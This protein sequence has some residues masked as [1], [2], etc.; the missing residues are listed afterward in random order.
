MSLSDSRP[1]ALQSHGLSGKGINFGSHTYFSDHTKDMK[2]L[3]GCDQLNAGAT[4]KTT[5]T[6]KTIHTIHSLIDSNKADMIKM[7]V[8]PKW[9]S[10]EPW[11][12]KASWHLSYRWGETPKKTSPRKLVPTGDRTRAHCVTG[13][14]AT[15]CS[16][17]VDL[18]HIYRK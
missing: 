8:M 15:A 4:S 9:Y 6:L 10:G 2:G 13:A 17:A 1:R 5:R 14:H 11:G 16:T 12:P 7:I 3:P 18:I